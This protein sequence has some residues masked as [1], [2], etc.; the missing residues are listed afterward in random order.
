MSEEEDRISLLSAAIRDAAAAKEWD[1]VRELNATLKDA[2]R[3]HRSAEHAGKI[4]RSNAA[5][6]ATRALDEG[7]KSGPLLAAFAAD[8]RFGSLRAY[9]DARGINR[10]SLSAYVSGRYPCPVSVDRLIRKDF[11]H[12]KWEWPGGLSK[13]RPAVDSAVG[14]YLAGEVDAKTAAKDAG[15]SVAKFLDLLDTKQLSR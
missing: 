4:S 5:F 3:Q 11:P 8:P 14:K 13:R 12:L 7:R 15:M 2:L 1:T 9:A 10:A 6:E